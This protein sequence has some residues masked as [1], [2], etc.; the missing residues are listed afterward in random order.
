MPIHDW[1]RVTAGTWHDFHLAWIV[2]TSNALNGG[3]QWHDLDTTTYSPAELAADGAA[4]LGMGAQIVGGC[5]GT[6]PDHITALRRVVPSA[7]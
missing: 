6:T 2:Q 7:H 5:C 1:T 4:W 3:R